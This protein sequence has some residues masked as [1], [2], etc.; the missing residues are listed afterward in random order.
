M[1]APSSMTPDLNERLFELMRQKLAAELAATEEKEREL[2][3]KESDA[4]IS[5][6]DTAATRCHPNMKIM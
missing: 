5:G 4:R 1:Q 2:M 3:K 6:S